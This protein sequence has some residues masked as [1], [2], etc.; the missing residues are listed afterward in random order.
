MQP[1]LV[2]GT[3]DGCLRVAC[4][5]TYNKDPQNESGGSN[6][7]FMGNSMDTAQI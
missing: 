4:T 5:T 3:G 2:G 1:S 6:S 7:K